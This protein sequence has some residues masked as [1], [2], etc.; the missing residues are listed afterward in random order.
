MTFVERRLAP[1]YGLRIALLVQVLG[2]T[3]THES[4]SLNISARGI[5]FATDL[6]VRKGDLVDLIFD[7]PEKI[8]RAPTVKWRC[9]GHVVYVQQNNPSRHANR[10]GVNFV[11]YEALSTLTFQDNL[12]SHA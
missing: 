2:T 12:T 11:Y 8:T 3:T 5:C 4:E 7:M 10:V 6:L 9:T 1:R